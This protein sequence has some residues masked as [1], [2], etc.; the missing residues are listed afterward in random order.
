M[1]FTGI[2]DSVINAIITQFR[3][4][5][6]QEL[7][8]AQLITAPQI[9]KKQKKA[10][11]K[12]TRRLST[13]L[14]T[15]AEITVWSGG[16]FPKNLARDEGAFKNA[17]SRQL[18]HLRSLSGNKWWNNA[19]DHRGTFVIPIEKVHVCSGRR[20]FKSSI[21]QR[22]I[23]DVLWFPQLASST[24]E[25]CHFPRFLNEILDSAGG[26]RLFERQWP[27]LLVTL[28]TKLAAIYLGLFAAE[29]V[30]KD[31]LLI[32]NL[33][34]FVRNKERPGLV[35]NDLNASAFDNNKVMSWNESQ[36][37]RSLLT[38]SNHYQLNDCF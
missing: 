36:T 15:W 4:L 16:T 14:F 5:S 20:L 23:I 26:G 38:S 10:P 33:G 19:G 1:C 31:N 22:F 28:L 35:V 3:Q 18:R 6:L 11:L 27:L 13:Y 37:Y 30:E 32:G 25:F 17:S 2:S 21:S 7:I 24:V 34:V 12:T 9:N 29:T 8:G